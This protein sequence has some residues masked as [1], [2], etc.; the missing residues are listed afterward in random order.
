MV[1]EAKL[2]QFVGKIPG[3]SWGCD[4]RATGAH[5]RQAGLIQRPQR[6]WSHDV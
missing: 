1:D 6:A 2:K 4:E 3:R 5:G